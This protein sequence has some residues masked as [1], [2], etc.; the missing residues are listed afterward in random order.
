MI[1]LTIW[2]KY[3]F[4]TLKEKNL[5]MF[6]DNFV[7]FSPRVDIWNSPAMDTPMYY[8]NIKTH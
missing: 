3:K 2:W 8:I 7:V 5:I 1:L 6:S 4:A